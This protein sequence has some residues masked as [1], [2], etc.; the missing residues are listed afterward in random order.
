M[1]GLPAH[2]VADHADQD[3]RQAREDHTKGDELEIAPGHGRLF[4]SS[5]FSTKIR[6]NCS[7]D[8]RSLNASFSD[9]SGVL[10][11]GWSSVMGTPSALALLPSSAAGSPWR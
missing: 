4:F 7:G 6:E 10:G 2:Q 5:D 11:V 8:S 1:L 3:E 9:F